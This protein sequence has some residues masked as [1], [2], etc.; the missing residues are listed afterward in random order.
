MKTLGII[1]AGQLGQQIAHYALSD[2]HYD[3]VVFFDDFSDEKE[4]NAISVLGK[5]NAIKAAFQ[6]QQFDELLIGI[7]Y[8]HLAVRKEMFDRFSEQIPFGTLV[9]SSTCIDSSASIESGC[10]IY[11]GCIIDAKVLICA[12]TI[13]NIGCTIAHDTIVG[14]HSFLSPRVAVAGFVTIEE[15]CIIGIN[16]TIIDTITITNNTQLGGGTVV[17]QSIH[18]SGLYVGNPAKFIR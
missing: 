11:P 16:S 14:K 17:I 9:H 2:K 13:L 1:G 10:V 6:S 15:Q 8:K 18:T 5:T 4:V 7:G 3:A 12:N